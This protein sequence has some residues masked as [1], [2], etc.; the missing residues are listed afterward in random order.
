MPESDEQEPK[1]PKEPKR[2]GDPRE[3]RMTIGEH[4]EE[5][6]SCLL[7]ALVAL[8]VACVICIYPAKWLLALIARPYILVARRYGQETSFLQTSPVEVI[9]IYIKVVLIAGVVIAAPII[10]WQ[11]WNFV[12]A[13]LYAREKKYVYRLVPWSVGLFVT[14]VVFMYTLVLLVSLGFLVRFSTWLPL[15]NPEPTFWEKPLLGERVSKAPTTQ[16]GIDDVPPVPLLD[17]D[18]NDPPSGAVWF[19]V[20]EQK[21]KLRGV[22]ETWSLR[23]RRDGEASMIQTHLKIGDYLSFIL[24]MTIAFGLAFQMPL[25]VYFLGRSGLVPV[26]SLRKYRKFVILI[27]VFIAGILA[28]PDLFSHLMLSGPMILLFELGLWLAARKEKAEAARA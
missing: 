18:P 2:A 3:A 23:L 7:R 21:L 20:H 15:P 6:R 11:L 17:E 4:L 13:G 28:P 9:L 16:P 10:I 24:I 26:E 27:I 14:G 12:A 8:V 1:R 5:L 25:V 19:N 22:K